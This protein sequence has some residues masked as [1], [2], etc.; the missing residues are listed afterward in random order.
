MTKTWLESAI[1]NIKINNLEKDFIKLK[2][3][4]LTTLVFTKRNRISYKVKNNEI[5][6]ILLRDKTKICIDNK[7]IKK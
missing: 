4:F 3:N 6:V 1:E 2:I 7:K 5:T